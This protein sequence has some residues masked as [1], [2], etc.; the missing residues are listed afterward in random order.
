MSNRLLTVVGATGYIGRNLQRHAASLGGLDLVP[1]SREQFDVLTSTASAAGRRQAGGGRRGATG[2]LTAAASGRRR[3]GKPDTRHRMPLLLSQIRGSAAL[4]NLAGAGRQSAKR[5]YEESVVGTV[6]RAIRLCR[7]AKIPRI[8]HLS[9]L[10]ASAGSPIAY[11]AAKYRA[12]SA[13]LASGLE[14][15]I[16]RP[17]YVVGKNDYLTRYVMRHR[18]GSRAADGTV[19]VPGRPES[20]RPIQPVHVCDAVRIILWGAFT[21]TAGTRLDLVG[22]DRITFHEYMS[23]LAKAAGVQVRPVPLE[24]AYRHALRAPVSAPFG[25]DDLGIITGGFVGSYSRLCRATGIRPR[26]VL[27]ILEAGSLP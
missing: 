18:S 14:Y 27:S 11:L 10:G 17:S 12:E 1:L 8:V 2:S 13:I 5:P 19:G 15:V 20:S 23:F 3:G 26:S 25:I 7:M 16:L 9:G 6:A 21:G 24:E 4:I 22:P